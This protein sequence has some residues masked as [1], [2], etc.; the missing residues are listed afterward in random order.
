MAGGMFHR[1]LKSNYSDIRSMYELIWLQG[2]T[3]LWFD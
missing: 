2:F 3:V 1:Q